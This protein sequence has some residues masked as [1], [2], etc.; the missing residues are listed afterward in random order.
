MLNLRTAHARRREVAQQVRLSLTLEKPF[1]AAL[2][3]E[4]TRVTR[5]AATLM[6]GNHDIAKAL[7]SH[8]AALTRIFTRHYRVISKAFYSR[9]L[10]RMG[11]HVEYALSAKDTPGSAP[12]LTA[13]V[14]ATEPSYADFWDGLTDTIATRVGQVSD[15]TMEQIQSRVSDG[16]RDG[17]SWAD[18]ASDISDLGIDSARADVIARTEA[19]SVSQASTNAAADQLG[20]ALTK[21]WVAVE[22]SRTRPDHAEA[23]GQEV[24]KESMFLVGG[25]PMAFPGDQS[26]PADQVINCRCGTV[27]NVQ[28]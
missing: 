18:I 9:A 11:K 14:V 21:V 13:T 12:S 19:H 20:L 4:F 6:R 8:R 15:T 2:R 10:D 17:V 16:V 24:D 25:S 7:P 3:A 23:D 5:T 27:F 26:A 28:E 22:D 1:A